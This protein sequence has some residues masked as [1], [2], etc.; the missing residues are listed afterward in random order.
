MFIFFQKRTRMSLLQ[1][2]YDELRSKTQEF[3]NIV[4]DTGKTEINGNS[5]R[6]LDSVRKAI[7][8]RVRSHSVETNI[9]NS[10]LKTRSS[11]ST[12]NSSL[13]SIVAGEVSQNVRNSVILYFNKVILYY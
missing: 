3:C 7:T 10:V 4:S 9:A 13:S 12:S 8:S 11:S 5:N 2:L 1:S 6:F